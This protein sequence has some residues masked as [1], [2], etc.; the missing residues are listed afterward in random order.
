M[1]EFACPQCRLS[2]R[3]PQAGEKVICPGCSQW[4]QVPS[5]KVA[6]KA[7][8]SADDKME[9]S[10][11]E[12][13]SK[14]KAPSNLA[15]SSAKCPRCGERIT[16]PAAA[17]KLAVT[18]T[19]PPSSPPPPPLAVAVPEDTADDTDYYARR[20]EPRSGAGKVVAWIAASVLA[21]GGIA[22]LVL[23]FLGG[24]K[25]SAD[26]E[27]VPRDA[28][29]FATVRV[30]EVMEAPPIKKMLDAFKVMGGGEANEMMANLKEAE[31]KFGL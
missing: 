27:L 25:A 21:I 17:G 12:C 10:C 14:V 15:G 7:G 11:P 8:L 4:V 3:H 9:F 19:M 26:F 1:I 28:Q 24:S 6:P 16:I 20:R 22:A 13:Q 5:P 30:A 31:E 18:L 29:M 2:L 23:F